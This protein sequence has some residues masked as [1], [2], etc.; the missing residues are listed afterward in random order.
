VGQSVVERRHGVLGRQGAAT[1][2]R[3]HQRAARDEER[4]THRASL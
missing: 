2:M 3:K 4:V 1:A